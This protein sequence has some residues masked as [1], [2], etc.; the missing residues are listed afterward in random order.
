MI[1]FG[2]NVKISFIRSNGLL[3]NDF[4]KNNQANPE[5]VKLSV[6]LDRFMSPLRGLIIAS[7]LIQKNVSPSG[8]SENSVLN[9]TF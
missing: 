5:G 2:I 8:L 6:R 1:V 7:A 9:S 4:T 3:I